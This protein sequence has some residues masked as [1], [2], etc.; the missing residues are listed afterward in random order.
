M[1]K[2]YNNYINI[3]LPEKDLKKTIA[4]IVTDATPLEAPKIPD[5]C[6]VFALY[7]LLASSSQVAEMRDNYL[8][9]GYGYGHAKQ[10]LFALILERFAKERASYDIYMADRGLLD[11]KLLQGAEKARKIARE[12]LGRVRTRLGY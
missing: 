9:G 10:A 8:R 2:S 4:S 7:R 5:T 3:F 6:N 11:E 12:V 1:S